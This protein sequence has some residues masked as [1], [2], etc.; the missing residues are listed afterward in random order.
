MPFRTLKLRPGVLLE[1]SPTLNQTNLAASN[2]I[3]FYGGLPQKLGGWQQLTSQTFVGT[4]RGLH[5]WADIVGNPYVAVGTEQRLQVLIGGAMDDITPLAMTDNIAV[6]FTTTNTST[7]VEINDGSYTP[8]VGDWINLITPVSQGGIVLSGFYRV[9]TNIDTTHYTVT[10]ASPATSNAGPGG[11]VPQ[12][13]T[14]NTQTAVKVTLANHP[15]TTG[16]IY[17]ALISTT[18]GGVTISGSYSVTYVDANNFNIS[19]SVPA[20][21]STSAYMNTGNAQIEYLIPTGFSVNTG[22]TGYGTGLYGAGL[23]GVGGSGQITSPL[24]QWSL[25]HFGQD[26]IACPTNGAIYYWQPATVQPA[27][28][29]TYAP[30]YSGVTFVMPQSEII[31]SLAAEISGTQEPLLVRWCTV[32]SFSNSTDWT[33]TATNQAGSYSIAT[34]NKCVGG[35][36]VGL[37]ALIWTDAGLWTVSYIGFPLVFGFNNVAQGCGLIGQRGAGTVGTL[38]MWLSTRGFFQYGPGGSV[39]PLECSVWDFIINNID[40]TQTGQIH[41][42][43]NALFNEMAW[44]F[45]LATSSVFWS[46]LAPMA[47]VKYNYL[48][49][50]WDYGLSSQYQRTAS[51]G[52]SPIGNPVGA[53]LNGLLQQHE[54]GTDAN[55]AGMQ[56][57]WQ[58]GYF[59]LMEGEDFIFSDLII[60]D[61]VSTGNPTFT[62]TVLMTDY[63]NET[64][65]QAV[66]SGN[67]TASSNF[68]TYSAR[69]RQMAFGLAGSDLGTF[70]R[71]GAVR[72]RFSP[73]GKN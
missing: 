61:F 11:A 17:T 47:Y 60:P 67:I 51:M 49:N 21:S 39:V 13:T 4:C 34:G 31:M 56:W 44:H 12:Y 15:F 48:E 29:M 54:V 55:G 19:A 36:A 42:A 73:D 28:V 68:I 33:A 8:N 24:R 59:E 38:V 6:A 63:P 37:G 32:G 27:S 5:G 22:L 41:C 53:D 65:T 3:R 7:S 50:C 1:Q 71:L 43:V 35:L 40:L 23:Y 58:T 2:L 20:S 66:V 46:A 72:V 16:S 70:N 18:V 57:S 52:V 25:D 62:P 45:P 14:V 10:A 30:L 26:L 9:A 64:P 69:G